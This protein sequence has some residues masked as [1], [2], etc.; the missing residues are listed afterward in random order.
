MSSRSNALPELQRDDRALVRRMLGGDEE[1][2]EDFFEGQFPGLYRF[3]LA[4]LK[5]PDLT[6]EIVQTAICKAIANLRSYRGEAS[7]TAWLFT[8]CRYEIS[9]H[10]RKL[11]RSPEPVELAEE[12]PEVRAALESVP[13]SH[14][15]PEEALRR[16]EIAGLVHATLDHLPPRYGRALEWKYVDGLS[17]KEI[18]QR[19]EV[20]PKA[21]ESLL[22]RARQAFRDGYSSFG[23]RRSNPFLGWIAVSCVLCLT[24][25][26]GLGWILPSAEAIEA[27]PKAGCCINNWNDGDQP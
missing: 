27:L 24:F 1:A 15:S 20:G 14:T 23:Q 11:R 8:I 12:A 26:W 3:A 17:V 21:A 2:F 5:D 18:A 10:Y 25:F 16:K 22:T 7:L 13:A 4:R 19:L 6:R 9:G